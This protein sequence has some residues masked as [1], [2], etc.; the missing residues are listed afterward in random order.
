MDNKIIETRNNT[1]TQKLIKNIGLEEVEKT[2]IQFGMY[3]AAEE[4][5]KRMDN[6]YISFS[7]LRYMSQKYNWKRKCNPKSPIYKG[8]LAGTVPAAYYKHLIFPKEATKYETN[9]W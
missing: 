3:R 2:W 5:S 4:L 9:K 8:V 7:T 1:M 6:E